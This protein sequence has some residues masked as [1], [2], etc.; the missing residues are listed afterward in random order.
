MKLMK[1]WALTAMVGALVA[2]NQVAAQNLFVNPGFEDPITSDGAP[3][4]GFWEAFQGG[5]ATS[6]RDT[7]DPRN[8]AGHL[9]LNIN[10]ANNTFA[11]AFQDVV[12][13]PGQLATLSFWHKTTSLPYNL[14]TE[15]RIEWRN[16]VANTE[17]SRTPN[18]TLSPTDVY[19]LISVVDTVPAGA[20]TARAVYAIQS[21]TNGALADLGTVYVDDASF[22]A[23]PEP[24]SALLL[25]L[26]AIGSVVFARRSRS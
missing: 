8:G 11:G 14:V 20:D 12:V 18:V 4:V 25:T 17:I 9:S 13:T 10:N 16:T 15:V 5:G 1:L 6:I 3:F 7:V 26:G 2:A 21:F 23:I 22:T 24:A 19:S